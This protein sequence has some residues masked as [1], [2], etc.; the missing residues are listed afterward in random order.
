MNEFGTEPFPDLV[1]KTAHHRTMDCSL[2]QNI[3]P[4]N[5]GLFDKVKNSI[6]FSQKETGLILSGAKFE[7]L[8]FELAEKIELCDMKGYFPSLPRNLSAWFESGNY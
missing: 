8:P 7:T 3:C 4:Q 1:P 5:A 2:C 6:E